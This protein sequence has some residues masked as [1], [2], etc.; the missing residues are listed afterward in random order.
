MSSQPTG[1]KET[2]AVA[3][4]KALEIPDENDALSRLKNNVALELVGVLGAHE[5][6]EAANPLGNVD[7]STGVDLSTALP[8]RVI[9]GKEPDE[10]VSE[11]VHAELNKFG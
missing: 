8:V 7:D 3:H 2:Y 1:D 4:T 5:T 10:R 9:L 11:T 6:E